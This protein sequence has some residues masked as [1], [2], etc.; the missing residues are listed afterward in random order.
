[1][2]AHSDVLDFMRDHGLPAGSIPATPTSAHHDDTAEQPTS[3]RH[4]T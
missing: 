4:A 2:A 3:E 1:V